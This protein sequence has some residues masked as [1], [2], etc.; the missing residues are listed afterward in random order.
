MNLKHTVFYVSN[1]ASHHTNSNYAKS[2]FVCGKGCENQK[3]LV[4]W[5]LT[6]LYHTS[7]RYLL[8]IQ[9]P[10]YKYVV[11]TNVFCLVK[12]LIKFSILYSALRVCAPWKFIDAPQLRTTDLAGQLANECA[13]HYLL[14]VYQKNGITSDQGL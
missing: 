13:A 9:A 12:L 11:K 8:L 7:H 4:Q 6:F 10:G 14:W 2:K 5:F 3:H 1:A